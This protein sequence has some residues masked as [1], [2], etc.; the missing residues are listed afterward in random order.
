MPIHLAH[1]SLTNVQCR[2]FL[3][4]WVRRVKSGLVP[5]LSCRRHRVYKLLSGASR[6]RQTRLAAARAFIRYVIYFSFLLQATVSS[7]NSTL[8]RSLPGMDLSGTIVGPV[9]A[10][11]T[12]LLVTV[13]ADCLA[14]CCAAQPKCTAYSFQFSMGLLS[15]SGAA[16]CFLYA[17]VTYVVPASGHTSGA[18]TSAYS[19]PNDA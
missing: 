3:R 14:A 1:F 12:V 18:L 10:P 13:E 19:A 8:F 5:V 11:G 4:G 16:P 15:G 2:L 7:C 9:G 6:Y 17:N